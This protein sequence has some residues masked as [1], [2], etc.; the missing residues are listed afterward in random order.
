MSKWG[1]NSYFY[2]SF[3]KIDV[4]IVISQSKIVFKEISIAKFIEITF[5]LEMFYLPDWDEKSVNWYR[6][7]FQNLVVFSHFLPLIK[8]GVPNYQFLYISVPYDNS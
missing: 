2:F 7:F 1:K 5:L 4:I 3:A 6:Y 8:R